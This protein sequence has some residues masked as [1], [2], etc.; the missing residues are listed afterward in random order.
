M[1]DSGDEVWMLDSFHRPVATL[2]VDW[3][4]VDGAVIFTEED[5]VEEGADRQINLLLLFCVDVGDLECMYVRVE[6]LHDT[7]FRA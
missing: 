1:T 3:V 6:F 7:I 5:F 2:V 4:D